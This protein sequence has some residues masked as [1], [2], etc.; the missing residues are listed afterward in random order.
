MGR[1]QKNGPHV[2]PIFYGVGDARQS[3]LS[4]AV[5]RALLAFGQV[6]GSGVALGAQVVLHLQQYGL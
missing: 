2:L 3:L 4:L 5:G 1:A 6:I